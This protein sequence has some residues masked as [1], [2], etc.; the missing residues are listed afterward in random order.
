MNTNTDSMGAIEFIA[1]H[2]GYIRALSRKFGRWANAQDREEFP[3]A[4]ALRILD[5][6]HTYNDGDTVNTKAR[7]RAWLWHQVRACAKEHMRAQKRQINHALHEFKGGDG[8]VL[9]DGVAGLAALPDPHQ[10]RVLGEVVE[11][12]D[13]FA[14]VARAFAAADPKE[15]AAMIVVREGLSYNEAR[16]RF[17][18]TP[19]AARKRCA[20]L[21]RRLGVAA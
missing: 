6:W 11:A 12:D 3:Q 17:G 1:R 16:E 10:E 13:R 18:T 2:Q 21:G 5:K 19:A 4:V 14:L 20:A 9:C 7:E 15:R 8:M